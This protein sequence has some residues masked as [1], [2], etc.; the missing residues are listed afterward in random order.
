ME[1]KE[2]RISVRTLVEFILRSGDIN[3]GSGGVRDTEAMQK[4]SKI[5]RKIQRSMGP[6]YE[7]EVSLSYEIPMKKDDLEFVVVL[8]GRAD[9]IIKTKE[10]VTIDEIKGMYQ[11]VTLIEEP[12]LLRLLV[13]FYLWP[14]E[15]SV[16]N[17]F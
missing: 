10:K 17:S 3:T 12:Y 11:D 9:G 1:T 13:G 16:Y 4:G 7:A 14:I 15:G 2:I 8:D 5:H 6:E